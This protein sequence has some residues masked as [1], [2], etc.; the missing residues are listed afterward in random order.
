MIPRLRTIAGY[1]ELFARAYPGEAI[2]TDT[3]AK[4]LATFERTV[5]SGVAPVDRWVEGEA[6]A[7]SAAAQRGFVLFNDKA[8][9]STCHTGWRFTDDGFYDIG[10]PRRRRRARAADAGH[11]PGPVR[12]QGADAAQC[13]RA[14]ALPAQRFGGHARRGDRSTIEA[15]ASVA[16]SLSPEI[17][18]LGLTLLEKQDLLAFLK[19]LTS[20][21]AEARIPALPR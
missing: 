12:V 17:K 7:L 1:H 6:L 20:Q 11:S 5:V 15:D 13:R 2:T 21:D 4:A 14:R 16:P 18:P 19:A 10:V 8:H 3:V 9:C